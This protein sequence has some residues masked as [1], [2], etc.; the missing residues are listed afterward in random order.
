MQLVISLVEA[1]DGQA[2][3]SLYHWLACDASVARYGRVTVQALSHQPGDMGVASD[4]INAVFADAGAAAG[5]GS[6]LV[7]YRT[8]RDTRT[9]APAF[10]IEKDGVA[11]VIRQGSEQEIRQI[12]S[13]MLPDA[14]AGAAGQVGATEEGAN[15]DGPAGSGEIP[16]RSGWR[17]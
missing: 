10:K 2:L 17:A 11:V 8:W 15:G 14:G 5:I 4:V 13:V 16:R 6:L 1:G 12:L 3:A 9:Q 7:A